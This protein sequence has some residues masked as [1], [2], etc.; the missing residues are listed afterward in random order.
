M[1]VLRSIMFSGFAIF[2]IF[3]MSV[4]ASAQTVIGSMNTAWA[5]GGDHRID[6]ERIDDP[7]LPV[8]C[9]ISHP[10]TGGIKGFFGLAKN[11]SLFSISCVSKPGANVNLSSIPNGENILSQRTSFFSKLLTVNRF[12]DVENNTVVYMVTAQNEII[13]GS[14]FSS[15]SAILFH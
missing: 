13:D 9:Y 6:I 2:A 14:P 15:T 7:K 12:V 4:G 11:H 8:S 5:I 1:L 3:L 10:I